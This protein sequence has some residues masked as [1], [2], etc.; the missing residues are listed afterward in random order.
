MGDFVQIDHRD[1]GSY[2]L[3]QIGCRCQ[4]PEQLTVGE[5]WELA[6][7][8]AMAAVVIE[9]YERRRDRMTNYIPYRHRIPLPRDWPGPGW[10]MVVDNRV[11]PGVT[12][13][14]A[15]DVDFDD[16]ETF[17]AVGKIVGAEGDGPHSTGGAREA[18]GGNLASPAP[19]PHET[20]PSRTPGGAGADPTTSEGEHP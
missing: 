15:G 18:S 17:G 6:A 10:K 8:A 12:Y 1:Y 5:L 20:P 4:E 16:P 2:G 3:I 9:R 14:I 13:M 11:P 19:P 7:E